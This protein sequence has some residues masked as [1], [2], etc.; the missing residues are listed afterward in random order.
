MPVKPEAKRESNLAKANE[1]K[2]IKLL[3]SAVGVVVIWLYGALV[4][5]FLLST[6]TDLFVGHISEM[7]N[8]ILFAASCGVF[9]EVELVYRVLYVITVQNTSF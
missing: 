3:S 1:Q 7:G 9:G 4:F 6:L 2:P 5:G 8:L